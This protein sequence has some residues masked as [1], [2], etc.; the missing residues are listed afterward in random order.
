MRELGRHGIR[1][2]IT[3]DPGARV[4]ATQ[5]LEVAGQ[6]L[7]PLCTD[8]TGLAIQP[9]D[10]AAL[11]ACVA[12]VAQCTSVSCRASCADA[13]TG[14]GGEARRSGVKRRC[15][16][17]SGIPHVE[18]WS[19]GSYGNRAREQVA[20]AHVDPCG[21]RDALRWGTRTRILLSTATSRYTRSVITGASAAWAA[22]SWEAHRL[23]ASDAAPVSTTLRP[24][25][26]DPHLFLSA[27]AAPALSSATVTAEGV[28]LAA[29]HRT[30][31][32]EETD[33]WACATRRAG[34]DVDT[35]I[36][37]HEAIISPPTPVM[38][39]TL[40]E[41][42][43]MLRVASGET[44]KVAARVAVGFCDVC[45]ASYTPPSRYTIRGQGALRAL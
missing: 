33:D 27:A 24:A 22:G 39:S 11:C 44:P 2:H 41:M 38:K 15:R 5:H 37:M 1:L 4:V 36:A 40:L 16:A 12:C 30:A 17:M 25:S 28:A 31:A 3:S 13:G 32:R 6:V 10:D 8:R 18:Y 29:R 19:A 43:M 14:I 23:A 20:R 34:R 21:R 45:G 26:C 9:N 35:G 7:E 42:A